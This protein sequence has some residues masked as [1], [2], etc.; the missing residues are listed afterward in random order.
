MLSRL[1]KRFLKSY[2]PYKWYNMTLLI[3]SDY[4]LIMTGVLCV[5]VCV[6]IYKYISVFNVQV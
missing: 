5:C 4:A 6:W 3:I 2:E 1:S